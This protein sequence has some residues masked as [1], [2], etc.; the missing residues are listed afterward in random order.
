MILGPETSAAQG[1]NHCNECGACCR[2]AP[3]S[4]L[5]HDVARIEAHVGRSIKTDIQI[6]R[7]KQGEFVVRM[8]PPCTFLKD[9]RCTIHEV[10]PTGGRQFECWNPETFKHRY[11]WSVS[12]IRELM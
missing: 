11:E 6:G 8:K 3:C 4:L 5:P 7:S 12:E 1:L 2:L 9:N 10:K